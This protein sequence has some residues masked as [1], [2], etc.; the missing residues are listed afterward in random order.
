MCSQEQIFVKSEWPCVILLIKINCEKL[1]LELRTTVDLVRFLG[2]HSRR[3]AMRLL[4]MGEE[5]RVSGVRHAVC[6]EQH[7]PATKK[8]KQRR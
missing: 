4:Q 3:R 1:L 6:Y 2:R 5:G 7:D 8:S